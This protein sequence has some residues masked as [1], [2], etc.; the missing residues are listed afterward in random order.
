ME[1]NLWNETECV[2]FQGEVFLGKV[3]R[4][5]GVEDKSRWEVWCKCV[6]M[7]DQMLVLPQIA[8]FFK[9]C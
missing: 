4:K 6:A 3:W 9:H 1:T 5:K 8:Q 2:E 7:F